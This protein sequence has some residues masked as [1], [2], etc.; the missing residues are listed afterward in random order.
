M[1]F[2][3][4]NGSLAV[5]SCRVDATNYEEAT[6]LILDAARH[7]KRGYVCA[8]NVHMIMEAH[9]D[10]SFARVIDGASLVTPDGMPLVWVMKALGREDQRRVYGPTLMLELLEGAARNDL[11]VGLLGGTPR[12]LE[13]LAARMRARYLGLRIAFAESPPFRSLSKDEDDRLVSRIDGSGARLLL[14]ALG[15][16]KQERWMA[17]H[18]DRVR[19]I[20][21]GVGAAFD[22]H[23]GTLRQAP[24]FLQ[25][26]GLEWAF[27]LAMEPRRL[28]MR[29]AKH[30]PRFFYLA[31]RQVGLEI[32]RRKTPHRPAR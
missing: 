13:K 18:A 30:N 10:P 12:V 8:A 19:P 26:C 5:V 29:Y 16:P 9:D 7:S 20:M 31:S 32:A 6:R 3:V 25:A 22:L 17:T 27:R 11:P 2:P 14:V 21:I 15:C 1:R 24:A 28:L 4:A 23:A